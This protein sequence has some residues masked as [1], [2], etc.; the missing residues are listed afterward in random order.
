MTVITP[1]NPDLEDG[2]ELIETPQVKTLQTT[3][4]TP[5]WSIAGV[6]SSYIWGE[7]SPENPLTS[8]S[9]NLLSEQEKYFEKNKAALER[10]LKPFFPENLTLDNVLEFVK[11]V[12]EVYPKYSINPKEDL[13]EQIIKRKQQMIQRGEEGLL[14]TC[15]G[16]YAFVFAKTSS[17]V[18]ETMQKTLNYFDQSQRYNDPL[19]YETTMLTWFA[20]FEGKA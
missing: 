20:K 19:F 10:E 17:S 12:N 5:S 2:W 8:H 13:L 7:K 18:R 16:C 9:I 3:P 14:K 6:V 1:K 4:E 15:I 11:S